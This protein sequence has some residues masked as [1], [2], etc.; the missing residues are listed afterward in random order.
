MSTGHTT[1]AVTSPAG[2]TLQ[3]FLAS[4]LALSRNKAKALIDSRSVLV[5][6]RRV[7]M[8]RHMVRRGDV[9]EVM[10]QPA[11]ASAAKPAIPV[12]TETADFLV[13]NKPAGLLANGPGSVEAT[14]RSERG[15]PEIRA[16]HRLDRDTSG[17]LLIARSAAAFDSAVAAF[18]ERDVGK[19]YRAIA[20]GR[21]ERGSRDIAFPLDGL[22]ARTRIS[23]I[24]SAR[25]ASYLA[26]EIETGRTHQIRRHLAMVGHPVLGDRQH[27]TQRAVSDMQVSVAR[28]MLHAHELLFP[29][30]AGDRVLHAVA[31]LPAD[32][33]ECLR[34]FGLRDR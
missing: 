27:W 15:E 12:L 9:V 14:L 10:A 5:N 18:R 21:M 16:A 24:S 26:V 17:C 31:P 2:E 32:F 19:A 34:R 33:V 28:Q 3:D 20:A 4:R 7:W 13:V 11:A 25:E 6:R 29:I 1:L 23:V 22:A 8:A 30:P